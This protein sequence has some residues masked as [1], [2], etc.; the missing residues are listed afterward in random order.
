MFENA[1]EKKN[2]LDPERSQFRNRELV[3]MDRRTDVECIRRMIV[4]AGRY[5]RN[6]ARVIDA[7]RI[8]VNA[9]V[10][11]RRDTERQRPEKSGRS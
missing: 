8:M 1:R 6:G 4:A 11:L 2:R 7:V 10:Q 9:F 5:E 3:E